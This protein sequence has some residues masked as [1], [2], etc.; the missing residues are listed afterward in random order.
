M[1]IVKPVFT[2]VA[3][4]PVST[5]GAVTTTVT[6]TTTRFFATITAGMI[7]ATVTTIPAAS[8]VDDANAP[9]VN[10]PT[11]TAND[12]SSYSVNG[13]VQQSSLF[14]LSTTSLVIDSTDIS[15]GVPVI[16]EISN[17]SGTASTISTQPTISA[18]TITITS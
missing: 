11:L 5:G 2:A 14:T 13:L 3:T 7:G 9:V 15:V 10:L 12:T 1:P 17:F 18:P 16:I 6:P 8:F 4:A